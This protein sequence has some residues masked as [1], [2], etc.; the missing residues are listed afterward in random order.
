M[1]LGMVVSWYAGILVCQQGPQG[2]KIGT[3]GPMARIGV[4]FKFSWYASGGHNLPKLEYWGLGQ[5]S[6]EKLKIPSVLVG[7]TR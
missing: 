2:A 6:Y 7:A 4:K 1:G 5:G 3:L